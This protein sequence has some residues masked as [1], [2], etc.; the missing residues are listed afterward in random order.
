MNKSEKELLNAIKKH[1]SYGHVN[2]FEEL[3]KQRD[4][5]VSQYETVC[6]D[7]SIERDWDRKTESTFEL[8]RKASE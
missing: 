3:V 2:T 6:D 7:D 5:L 1:F 4:R 8:I